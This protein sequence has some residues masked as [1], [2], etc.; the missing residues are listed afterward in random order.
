MKKITLL[1]VFLFAIAFSTSAQID[2]SLEDKSNSKLLIKMDS[3]IANGNYDDITSV[4]V[5][6][7]SKLI[8]EKYYQ[9]KDSSSLHNTRSATKSIA[10]ILAGI[11]IDK[12][13]ITSEKD[14]IY[15]Y[16]SSNLPVDNPDPR[17]DSITIEDLLTMSSVLECDDWNNHSRGHEERMYFIEDW[18][19]F[20][21]DLPV[22]AYPFNGPPSE[23][24]YGRAFGYASAKAAAV[25]DIVE[26]AVGEKLDGFLKTQLLEPL[27]IDD[28][29]LD[30]SPLGVLNTAGGSG[31][32]SRDF[33]KMIQL[34][35]N[36]GRW[37]DK[38]IVSSEWVEKAT[39]P[40]AHAYDIYD[41]GYFLWL[42]N[43][44]KEN[45]YKAFYMNGNGGNH[46]M[47]IPELDLCIVITATNYNN[48]NAH[49]YSYELTSK[50][51][52]PSI[53]KDN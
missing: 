10:T 17:K 34:L 1:T 42:R 29:K 4:L 53:E 13:Y 51:I 39:T 15:K 41:Y 36:N 28:Y 43:F 22:R 23:R 25:G 52:I 5:I 11:A 44:G 48:R 26:R 38:Q 46:I 12:G 30:Y 35:L 32:R 18:T 50:F 20:L 19:Q 49:D 6:K 47:A 31:Y 8:Y 14:K 37:N 21:L 45:Q 9:E 33:A 16:L 40:K 2:F 3:L 7:D 27:E 24:P